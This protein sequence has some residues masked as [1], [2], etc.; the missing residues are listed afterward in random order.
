MHKIQLIYEKLFQHFG[1]RGWWPV[2]PVGGC[3]GDKSFCPIYGLS[4]QSEMQKLEIMVGAILTQNTSWKNVEKAIIELN[5]KDLMSIP[6]LLKVKHDELASAIRSSGY[7]N[8]KAKKLKNMA[9]FLTQHSIK[10]LETLGINESRKLLLE[11]N[12]V[13]KET[14]DSI[15]LYALNKPIFVID[16]Y[17]KRI[18][19]RVGFSEETYDEFH[20][21][22]MKNLEPHPKLF[23][24]YHALIVELGK[25]ICRKQPLCEKCPIH[26]LCNKN[27]IA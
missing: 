26:A 7:Y 11:V 16:A 21:L 6:R 25:N 10:E 13:G 8:Q 20:D 19:Y 17:T 27:I 2:T 9:K 15:I 12:G 18:F 24:E 4:L 3:R 5:K 14:A 23:N 22:F 1:A